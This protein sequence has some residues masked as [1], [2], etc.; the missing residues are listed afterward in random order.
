MADFDPL[1]VGAL[2]VQ[3]EGRRELLQAGARPVG[4]KLGT[5]ERERIGAGPVVGYLTSASQLPNGGMYRMTA[6][7]LLHADAEVALELGIDGE[8][9][10]FGAALELVDLG[11]SDDAQQIVAD[12]VFHRA[13][14][15]GP[16]GPT[17]PARPMA[18]LIVNGEVRAQAR[19]P[20]SDYPRV[21][22]EVGRLLAVVG[23][24][25]RP[26]DRLITGAV[27][28]VPVESG[29]HV[30]ADLGVLG[31]AEA[32]ISSHISAVE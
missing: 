19:A 2:L 3:L 30:I 9:A 14:V 11:G 28:Q 20:S 31:R 29:D 22:H 32:R 15:F 1:L 24:C 21:V 26:G 18:R 10:G 4:W 5:G 17:G 13:A 27:V 25:I 6:D 7:A 23:D 12:N 8:I 16:V